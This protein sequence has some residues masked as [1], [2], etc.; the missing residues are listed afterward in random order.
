MVRYMQSTSR[1]DPDCLATAKQHQPSQWVTDE[2]VNALEQNIHSR[3][4][5]LEHLAQ[6]AKVPIRE[7]MLA[8]N[9][10]DD[11]MRN[12]GTAKKVSI[13]AA[14]LNASLC[15]VR[16]VRPCHVLLV[17]AS[18]TKVRECRHET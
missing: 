18:A 3:A 14:Q 5:Q 13:W 9:A 15:K 1:P 8:R 17:P 7:P 12:A 2:A 10:C 11:V 16:D 4:A 6:H